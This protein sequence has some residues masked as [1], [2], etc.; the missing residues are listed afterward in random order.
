MDYLFVDIETF[1][2][3]PQLEDVKVPATYKKP[4]SIEKYQIENLD[5]Q[6]RDNAKNPMTARILCISASINKEPIVS[7]HG[8]E[9]EMMANF[10]EWVSQ[11][12]PMNTA[13]VAHNGLG[14]DF[15][16]LLQRAF[17]DTLQNVYNLLNFKTRYDPRILDIQE[18]WK[19]TNY[20][21]FHS[22]DSVATFLGFEGKG[23]IDGSMVHDLFL[24]GQLAKIVEYCEDD[25]EK[26]RTVFYHLKKIMG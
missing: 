13:V 19:G 18:I 2:N 20:K 11:F 16:A 4:E 8:D 10:D 24:A 26:M 7:F 3:K 15:P 22:F 9:K 17:R 14:F 5:K 23:E 12:N 25:V 21:A 1:G 6:W